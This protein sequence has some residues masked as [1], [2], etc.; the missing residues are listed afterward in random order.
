MYLV[1]SRYFLIFAFTFPLRI[2]VLVLGIRGCP[3]PPLRQRGF[4]SPAPHKETMSVL[5]SLLLYPKSLS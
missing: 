4:A 3:T 5:S 2:L 1:L